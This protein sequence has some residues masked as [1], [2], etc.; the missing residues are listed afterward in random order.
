MAG[1]QREIERR[2]KRERKDKKRKLIIWIII[3]VIVFVLAVMKICE[4]NINSVKDRFTDADGNFTLTQGVVEDNFPYSIDS[5]DNVKIVNANNKI[6]VITPNSY[7]VL[8]SKD[9]EVVYTFDHGYSNPVLASS[10]VYS[11]VYDQ[12]NENYRLDTMSQQIYEEESDN[13]IL[14]ADVSKNGTVALATASSEKLCDINV[15]TKSLKN[16]FSLSISSGYVVDIALNSSSSKVAVAV[17]NSENAELVTDVY[18]YDVSSDGTSAEP[19]TLPSGTLYDICFAGSGLWTVGDTYLGLI[20]N[21]EY[22]ET[23]EQGTINIESYTY[24]TSGE[25]VLAYGGYSNSSQLVISCVKTNGK[26]RNEFDF[27]G[28]VK[29]VTATTSLISVLTND[30]IV[31]YNLKTGEQ[32]E[33]VEVS[34]SVKS[35][36][37][38][39]SSVYVHKQSVIDKCEVSE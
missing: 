37:R 28:S 2:E 9:G 22:K 14:C 20:K 29:S 11:L 25:I 23:Y 18:I 15:F 30:E 27:S 31:T 16:E 19:I 6:G 7:T 13:S 17:V 3:A 39:G 35:A 5:S 33:S 12:G 32:R 10:G 38:I 21:G 36:C 26:I 8:D 24:N 1:N 34:D 4:I